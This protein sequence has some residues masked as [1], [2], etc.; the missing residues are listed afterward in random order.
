MWV[1]VFETHPVRSGLVVGQ[2]SAT[3]YHG[4]EQIVTPSDATE[5]NRAAAIVWVDEANDPG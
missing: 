5:L 3:N 1:L 4:E 2:Q